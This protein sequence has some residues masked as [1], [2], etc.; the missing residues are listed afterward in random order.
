MKK[1][2]KNILTV[3]GCVTIYV[4]IILAVKWYKDEQSFKQTV[5][6]M[7]PTSVHYKDITVEQALNA[8]YCCRFL[9]SDK[10]LY[11]GEIPSD[12]VY[13]RVSIPL[14]A[15]IYVY[16]RDNESVYIVYTQ[17]KGGSRKYILTKTGDF[18]RH[19]EILY[20]ATGNEV[21]N[22]TVDLPEAE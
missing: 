11:F 18:N 13:I 6:S 22:E 4:V 12:S 7:L 16:P 1:K 15:T 2:L 20:Q 21:F 19:L 9:L 14:K 3:A 8:D 17:Q 5:E 10:R